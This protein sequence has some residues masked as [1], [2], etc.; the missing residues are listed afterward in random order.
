MS[1]LS[2]SRLASQQSANLSVKTEN[3]ASQ[4]I[5]MFSSYMKGTTAKSRDFEASETVSRTNG[6]TQKSV[7]VT[8]KSNGKVADKITKGKTTEKDKEYSVAELVA[9]GSID[10]DC[11]SQEVLEQVTVAVKDILMDKLGISED[12]LQ[13]MMDALSLSDEDLLNDDNIKALV[14]LYYGISDSVE[15]MMDEEAYQTLMDVMSAVETAT[16][17]L[18]EQ[19]GMT[20]EE[21]QAFAELNATTAETV[22]FS[23]LQLEEVA[24]GETISM[25]AVST[26][27]TDVATEDGEGVADAADDIIVEVKKTPADATQSENKTV[28]TQEITNNEST[29]NQNPMAGNQEGDSAMEDGEQN[30][31]IG[32]VQTTVQTI[33][34]ENGVQTVFTRLTEA[35]DMV[36]QIVEQIRVQISPDTTSMEMQLNPENLG[37]VSLNVSAKN[38]VVTAQMTVENDAVKAAVESQIVQL[39]ES[40]NNQGLKVEAIEVSVETRSFERQEQNSGQ[41]KQ[42]AEEIVEKQNTIRRRNINLREALAEGG[43]QEEDLTEEELLTQKLMKAHGNTVDFMA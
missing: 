3:T 31:T 30:Q 19:A 14:M 16:T 13:S 7:G 28:V 9:N 11:V 17:E 21:L 26:V 35:L 42:N 5:P 4:D 8:E 22:D 29:E 18:C 32:N 27:A 25:E 6:E 34:T 33:T 43:I 10:K 23:E 40:L 39:K 20:V 41:G 24:D 15:L 36:K 37:K 1:G 38:G 12:V 2:I